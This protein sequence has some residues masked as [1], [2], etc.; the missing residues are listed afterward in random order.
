MARY[1]QLEENEVR[2]IA[3]GYGLTPLD[4]EPLAG[5]AANS[6]YVLRTGQGRYV[7]TIFEEKTLDEVISIGQRLMLLEYYNFPT[8][9]LLPLIGG[10]VATVCRDKP[11]L[12]K[13]YVTGQVCQELN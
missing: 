5:G 1:T 13:V 3:R 8:T 11:V 2:K 10:G 6:S 12:V 4:F 9:R 7:L